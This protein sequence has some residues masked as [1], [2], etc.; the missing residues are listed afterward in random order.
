[1]N[2]FGF[3]FWVGMVAGITFSALWNSEPEEDPELSLTV[4]DEPQE[5]I[6]IVAEESLPEIDSMESTTSEL[7]TE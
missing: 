3:G 5:D 2:S 4:V 1:M 7:P 6:V